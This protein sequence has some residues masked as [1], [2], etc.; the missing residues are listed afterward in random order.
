MLKQATLHGLLS[1]LVVSVAVGQSVTRHT[2]VRPQLGTQVRIVLYAADSAQAHLAASAAYSRIDALNARLS[3]WL[4]HSE[5]S[6]LPASYGQPIAVSDD[7]WTVLSAAYQVAE[8]SSGHFDVTV[9]PLTRLWRWSVRRQQLP[10]QAAIKQA[11]SAVGYRYM[12]LDAINQTVKLKQSGMQLDLGGI[13]KG[14]IAD[15]ALRVLVE[16]GHES[17][18]VDAGGDIALGAPPPDAEGWPVQITIADSLG[19]RVLSELVL[20]H[21]GV[22][23][24]GPTFRYFEHEGT[25]YSHIVSPDTGMG[26]TFDR[27]VTVVATSGLQADAW[28]SAYSVM[29]VEA[30][31]IHARQVPQIDLY[32][33]E[34]RDGQ[35]VMQTSVR[36]KAE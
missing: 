7:L 27:I 11:K 23:A 2:F 6:Q 19:G 9:G 34:H 35:Q 1:A 18:M 28:A 36:R 26:V 10:D 29:D 15:E 14:Y 16:L 3:N 8:Q 30:A 5:V 21:C 20:S 25:R 32:I 22:A 13:A 17:S 12:E 24:S 31:V 4:V 33:V